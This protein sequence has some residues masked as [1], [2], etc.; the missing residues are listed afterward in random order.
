[1]ESKE[2]NIVTMSQL[3]ALYKVNSKKIWTKVIITTV[4]IVLYSFVH[5]HTYK[6]TTSIMP[7]K[8]S[9]GGGLSGL[10]Q[11][12][13]GAIPSGISLPGMSQ[14]N[15][16]QIL[17]DILRSR[18]VAEYIIDSL[19]L[20]KKEEF[21]SFT[22]NE[23]IELIQEMLEVESM[24][25]GLIV[26]TATTETPF[27]PFG[28]AKDNAKKFA[29]DIATKAVEGL[30]LAVRKRSTSAARKSREYVEKELLN[31]RAKSDSI[32]NVLENF[33]K[34][35]KVLKIDDQTQELVKQAIEVGLQLAKAEMELN[36]AMSEYS[37]SHPLVTQLK[38]VVDQLRKQY[39]SVQ[40]GGLTG[41]DGFSIP[42]DKIPNLARQY[43]NIFRDK[44]IFEQ[45]ILYLE[46]QRHQEAIQESR[47]IPVVE[48]L[49]KAYVPDKQSSPSKKM[50]LVLG[51]FLS[52]VFF[53]TY[54]IVRAIVTNAKKIEAKD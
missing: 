13:S 45:V 18:V 39:N 23:L 16:T 22:R 47:D 53:T 7:P 12:L 51:L 30:D 48:P 3:Y 20:A 37:K 38:S 50:M 11:G 1:M 15:Q 19:N 34:V 40:S 26:V 36:V 14:G 17:T 52:F 35:N 24:R 33:Q 9:E 32:D 25:S 49:D 4:V 28:D 5:P 54:H 31:Y 6:S 10:L 27:F 44:K 43:A 8:Q 21:E 46:T 42:F 2:N 41:S 29:S